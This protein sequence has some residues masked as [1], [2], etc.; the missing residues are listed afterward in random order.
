M[1]YGFFRTWPGRGIAGFNPF[2]I[3][4]FLDFGRGISR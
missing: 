1:E 2:A 3:D 4:T